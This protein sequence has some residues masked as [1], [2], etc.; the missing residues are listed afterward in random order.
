VLLF[1][2]NDSLDVSS[3]I[4]EIRL[5]FAQKKSFNSYVVDIHKGQIFTGKEESEAQEFRWQLIRAIYMGEAFP[6]VDRALIVSAFERL[7]ELAQLGL[8]QVD[9]L[10]SNTSSTVAASILDQID[11]LMLKV[12]EF[13][14]EIEPL[15]RWSQCEK[16]RI[17]PG[18]LKAVGAS[19]RNVY[20]NLLGVCRLYTISTSMSEENLG[21][22]LSWK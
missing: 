9:V 12:C 20:E 15:V 4:N 16:L 1:E 8:D 18:A 3:V 22:D 21:K 7:Q 17:P 14:P 19:T 13:C 6:V 11:I 5:M 10:M 2:S